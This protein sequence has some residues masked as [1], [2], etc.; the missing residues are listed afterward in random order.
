M[1][2]VNRK[3]AKE[4]DTSSVLLGGI[5]RLRTVVEVPNI[6]AA[7]VLKTF[8]NRN[9]AEVLVSKQ[10]PRFAPVLLTSVA[11]V[12]AAE[13]RVWYAEYPIQFIG[14]GAG[15][16]PTKTMPVTGCNPCE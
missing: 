13:T 10:A 9:E 4:V 12:E 1:P 15:L 11:L 3:P 14:F 7:L 6:G 2:L 16:L 8:T 5:G